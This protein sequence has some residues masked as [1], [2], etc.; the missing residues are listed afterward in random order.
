L[1]PK[2]FLLLAAKYSK[3]FDCHF[4]ACLSLLLVNFGGKRFRWISRFLRRDDT[5]VGDGGPST[6]AGI[7]P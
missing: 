3:V 7:A 6:M 5:F 2:S 4:Y 1:L